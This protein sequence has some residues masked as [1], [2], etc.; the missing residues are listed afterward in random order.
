M[1]ATGP[2][3]QCHTLLLLRVLPCTP[4]HTTGTLSFGG[5]TEGLWMENTRCR[6]AELPHQSSRINAQQPPPPPLLAG[7]Q[8]ISGNQILTYLPKN[9]ENKRRNQQNNSRK[10]PQNYSCLDRKG[11]QKVLPKMNQ[12]H[13]MKD[14]NG[15]FINTGEKE[16]TQHTS[17]NKNSSHTK[18]QELERF[19]LLRAT[20]KPKRQ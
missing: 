9:R 19:G 20:L 12:I 4:H 6:R 11:L 14:I 15:K 16:K 10:V 17:R 3:A 1:K 2:V 13:I 7:S 5:H 8:N 18:G